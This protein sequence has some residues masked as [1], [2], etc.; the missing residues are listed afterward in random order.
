MRIALFDDRLL[1]EDFAMLR[2]LMKLFAYSNFPKTTFAMSHPGDAAR[3]MKMR[4]NVRH[5]LHS[6]RT[7]GI[8][9]ALIA[10][11]VGYVIGRLVQKRVDTEVAMGGDAGAVFGH[12]PTPDVA[13][14]MGD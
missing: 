4:R 1:Q 10:I 2:N 9:A 7:A 6:K 3:I 11:P 13:P 12:A 8:G 14:V 5:T